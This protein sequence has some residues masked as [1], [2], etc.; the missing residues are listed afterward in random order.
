MRRNDAGRDA[1]GEEEPAPKQASW[2]LRF[3]LEAAFAAR[4]QQ[5]TRMMNLREMKK[6][7]Q[8]QCRAKNLMHVWCVVFV[9]P[10]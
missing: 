3:A 9:L 7:S 6:L 5:A 8:H 4:Q 10:V 1:E 2:L